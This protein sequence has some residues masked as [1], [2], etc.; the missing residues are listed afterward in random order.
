MNR[1]NEKL[2]SNMPRQ[3][4]VDV[5][6]HLGVG[7]VPGYRLSPNADERERVISRYASHLRNYFKK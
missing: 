3:R 4:R 1:E 7:G 6:F 5:E 2:F